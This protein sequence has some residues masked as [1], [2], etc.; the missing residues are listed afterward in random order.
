MTV[1]WAIH[2]P[3]L[4]PP[5][6]NEDLIRHHFDNL[7][8]KIYDARIGYTKYLEPVLIARSPEIPKDPEGGF[9]LLYDYGGDNADFTIGMTVFGITSYD[10]SLCNV[11]LDPIIGDS[12][13]YVFS[14]GTEINCNINLFASRGLVTIDKLREM[15]HELVK[16][17][18]HNDITVV[19]SSLS[20]SGSLIVS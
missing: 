8:S 15:Q 14:W 5:I 12:I 4:L 11:W 19:T 6:A 7:P 18:T 3:R 16:V 13:H 17:S 2:S 9:A 10:P 1:K 20:S